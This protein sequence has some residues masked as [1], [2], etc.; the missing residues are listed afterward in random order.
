MALPGETACHEV[1]PCPSS[2]WGDAPTDASTQFVDVSYAAGDSDGSTRKPWPSIIAA[3]QAA[4]PGATIAI[5]AGDYYGTVSIDKPIRLWGRCPRLVTLSGLPTTTL[6]VLPGADG[7][8]VHAIGLSGALHGLL[9]SGVSNLVIDRVWVHDF[10]GRGLHVSDDGLPADMTVRGSLIEGAGGFAVFSGGAR[11]VVEDTVVRDT[12]P[13][14]PGDTAGRGLSFEE[15]TDTGAPAAGEVRN[16][17]VVNNHDVGVYIAGASVDIEASLIG[18]TKPAVEPPSDRAVGVLVQSDTQGQLGGSLTLRQS[19]VV[20][21][22]GTGVRVVGSSLIAENVIVRDLLEGIAPVALGLHSREQPVTQLPASVTV[23]ASLVTGVPG[24]GAQLTGESDLEGVAFRNIEPSASGL[25]GRGLVIFRPVEVTAPTSAN[26]RGCAID[27]VSEF[28]IAAI[29]CDVRVEDTLVR[30]VAAQSIDGTFGDGLAVDGSRPPASLELSHVRV[31]A[32]FR[33]GVSNFAAVVRLADSTFEC[34][35][36]DLH[37][38][39]NRGPFSFEDLGGNVCGCGSAT[40]P[41]KVLTADLEPPLEP[42]FP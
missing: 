3:V 42:D 13:L 35:P 27:A 34:D 30:T 5:A 23:R 8:E 12:R 22:H 32:A 39:G 29:S 2:T 18:Y 1:A 19:S 40:A 21:D 9:A 41:C 7:T 16:A 31:E 24:F 33:A 4:A 38:A 11:L 17:V 15:G 26:V 25:A 6:E 28:G 20:G 14:I 37:G 10:D 36:I